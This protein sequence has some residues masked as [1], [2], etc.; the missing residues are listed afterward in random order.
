M[1]SSR[2]DVSRIVEFL[3]APPVDDEEHGSDVDQEEAEGAAVDIAD[4][5]AAQAD[6]MEEGDYKRGQRFKRLFAVL[7]SAAVSHD[8]GFKACK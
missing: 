1:S 6:V 7:S 4:D 8:C 2:V 5:A 3:Q